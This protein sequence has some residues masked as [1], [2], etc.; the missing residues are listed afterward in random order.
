M[1]GE[2]EQKMNKKWRISNANK[3]EALN[4]EI[5]KGFDNVILFDSNVKQFCLWLTAITGQSGE[6]MKEKVDEA[7]KNFNMEE[8]VDAKVNWYKKWKVRKCTKK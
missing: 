2:V 3:S 4:Q 6:D 8:V 7:L 1:N 5:R